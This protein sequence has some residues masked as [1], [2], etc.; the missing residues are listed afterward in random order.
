MTTMF[1]LVGQTDYEGDT[2]LGVYESHEA[3]EIAYEQYTFSYFT[4]DGYDIYP[5]EVGAAAGSR[6]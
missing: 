3:A 4:Y 2:V 6:W 1:V 5:I